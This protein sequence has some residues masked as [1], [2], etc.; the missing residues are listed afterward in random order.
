MKKKYYFIITLLIV[1]LF[2]L[3]S[4]PSKDDYVS[5]VKDESN[6]G[7]LGMITGPITDSLTT[8]KNYGVFSLYETKYDEKEEEKLLAVGLF[9]NFIWVN[10]PEEESTPK[11]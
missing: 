9:N 1:V 7:L 5:F 10:N 8:K 3:T 6:D 2:A 4:N 11:K